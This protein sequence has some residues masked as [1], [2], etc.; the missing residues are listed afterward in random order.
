M[1]DDVKARALEPFETTKPDG[2]GLG[3]FIAVR[4]IEGH[5]GKLE[6]DSAPGKGTTFIITLPPAEEDTP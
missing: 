6:L 2:T 5:G 1:T 4:I 3:L